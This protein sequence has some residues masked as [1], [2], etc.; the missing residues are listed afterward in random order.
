MAFDIGKKRIGI[1]VAD[2]DAILVSPLETYTRKKFSIDAP[3]LIQ[4]IKE[5]R[6]RTLVVGLP[7]NMDD[8]EGPMCQS[9]RDFITNLTG[10][11]DWQGLN[12]PAIIFQDERLST[13]ESETI[14]IDDLDLS[15]AKRKKVIDQMAAKAILERFLDY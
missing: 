9:V 5:W 7:L 2:Q 14:L 8:S 3:Y 4:L 15:R 12:D 1:A 10:H 13:A 11:E 6:V